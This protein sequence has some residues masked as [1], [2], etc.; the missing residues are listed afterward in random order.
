MLKIVLPVCEKDLPLAQSHAQWLRS[1]NVKYPNTAV[2]CLDHSFH[3]P[4]VDQFI[5]LV[6]Q[7]FASVECFR[8]PKPPVPLWPQAPNWAFQ[9]V[10]RHMTAQTDAWLWLEADASL[11]YGDSIQRIEQAYL[12]HGK[13]WMGAIVPPSNHLNGVAVYPHNAAE[14]MPRAMSCTNIAWDFIHP[15]ETAGDCH[16]ASELFCHVWVIDQHGNALKH[17]PGAVPQRF[18]PENM[19]HWIT[20]NAVLFHRAK[21]CSIHRLLEKGCWP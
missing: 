9:H 20:P 10:A 17:G 6:G 21:C 18:T 12:A 16:D 13:S 14:L 2:V 1:L 15:I 11:L 7:L 5:A 3:H 19:K 4:L 8:Y